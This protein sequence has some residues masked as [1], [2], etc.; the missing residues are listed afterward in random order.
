MKHGGDI[1]SYQHMYHGAIIDFSSNINPLGYPEIL[2]EVIVNG[3]ESLKAYP[4]IQYRA[5]Q[6]ALAEYL[7]CYQ[8][9][10]IVGNGAVEII[11]YFCGNYQRIVVCIPCFSEYI[12]RTYVHQKNVLKIPLS[13][14]FHVRAELLKGQLEPG[15]VLMLGNPNNPTGLRIKKSEVLQIQQ[16]TEEREAVLVLD[17]AFFEFC[18]EDY[19]SVRL[20]YGKEN[21]CVIRAAT[22]FFGLPGIRLGY[23]YAPP[24]IRSHYKEVVLPW[25]INAI[26]DLAGRVIFQEQEY[27]RETKQYAEQQRQFMLS[28][29]RKLDGIKVYD[30]DTNF[31]LMKLLHCTEDDLFLRLIQQGILIRKASSFEGLDDTYIRVAIKDQTSNIKLIEALREELP[32]RA[33]DV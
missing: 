13:E 4:D 3:L 1:V 8:D 27:I 12:E 7:G 6:Q 32:V 21:V 9:E 20:F 17:E 28:E 25:S 22:K 26:A 10:V 11:D 16:L 33:K 23:A 15:D 14:D 29:L 31:I 19:D 18:P 5:L 24:K 2:D 30:T